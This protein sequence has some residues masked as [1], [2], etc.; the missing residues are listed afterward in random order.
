MSQRSRSERRAARQRRAI[1]GGDVAALQQLAERDL[2]GAAAAARRA[3]GSAPEDSGELD[4]LAVTLARKLRLGGSPTKAL[5]LCAAGKRRTPELRMEEAAAAFAVGDDAAVAAIAAEDPL[6]SAALGPLLQAA[7]GEVPA[8]SKAGPALRLLHSAARAVAHVVRGE[9]KEARAALQRVPLAKRPAVLAN[10]ILGAAYITEPGHVARGLA[11]IVG[12]P[13]SSRAVLDLAM[14]EAAPDDADSATLPDA[15]RSSPAVARRAVRAALLRSPPPAQVVEI[16]R[17]CGP[18]LF[19]DQGPALLYHGFSLLRADP[20]AS[21]RSFDRAIKLGADMIEALRGNLIALVFLAERCPKDSPA[22]RRADREVASAADHLAHA[23][24]RDPRGGPFAAAAGALAADR[25]AAAA[26][27]RRAQAAIERAR[28]HA[29]GALLDR[30]DL[31]EAV[32]L[33][34][35]SR[36][37]AERRVDAVIARSPS[38]REAWVLKADFAA[39]QG[40]AARLAQIFTDAAAATKHPEFVSAARDLKRSLG[41]ISPFEGLVP[42]EASAG[43]LASE[44][45]RTTSATVDS[46]PLAAKHREALAPP[47]RFA[48]DAAALVITIDDEQP[49]AKTMGRLGE[50][51]DAWRDA[52]RDLGR[53]A[54][55]AVYAG[56]TSEITAALKRTHD[57][58]EAALRAVVEA[59]A[60]AGEGAAVSALLPRIAA[61]LDRVALSRLRVA[62]RGGQVEIPG[63]PDPRQAVQEIDRVLS[64]DFSIETYLDDD[65][66]DEPEEGLD[67]VLGMFDVV[68]MMGRI[69]DI[70][71]ELSA[72][73][74]KVLDALRERVLPI[75]LSGPSAA[76]TRKLEQALEEVGIRLPGGTGGRGRRR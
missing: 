73:P 34:I 67:D 27:P 47:A 17:A 43:V 11:M 18:E 63:V 48:F 46:Y 4:A 56:L 26:D 28:P 6:V 22:R 23:L 54:S 44:L 7:R 51:V 53:L 72:L 5:E 57:L 16:V 12:S 76:N 55:V 25:W 39:K 41:E 45:G 21:V 33:A 62:M 19:E 40:D 14:A 8:A 75:L 24:E 58:G 65:D 52:P 29:G 49:E 20:A 2:A 15:R 3:L 74:P 36:A 37:E 13:Q 69:F 68:G 32:A 9:P 30:L 38:N 1:V 61:S 60:V 71:A 35:T 10:E 50:L 64:P 42:G 59:F 66:D 70:S 31:L